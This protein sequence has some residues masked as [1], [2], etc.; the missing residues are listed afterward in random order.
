VIDAASEFKHAPRER[1]LSRLNKVLV[2]LIAAGV[3]V[4]VAYRSLPV[5]REK[6]VQENALAAAEANLEETRMLYKRL[7]REVDLLQ[8]DPEFIGMFARDR[9]SPGY[10]AAG[11]TIFRF[12]VP[13]NP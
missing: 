9:V 3:T 10:M 1:H 4:P 5:V 2:V 7:A 6:T 12:P 11:E 13:S 8:N